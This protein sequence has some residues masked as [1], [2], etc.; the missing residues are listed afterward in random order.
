MAK[1]VP[2]L[3]GLTKMIDGFYPELK[4]HPPI[5]KAILRGYFQGALVR[6]HM[7]H[8]EFDEFLTLIKKRCWYCGRKPSARKWSNI[9]NKGFAWNGIDRIDNDLPYTLDN[10]VSCCQTCNQWKKNKKRVDFLTHVKKIAEHQT[11]T[12]S[13][14]PKLGEDMDN[15]LWTTDTGSGGSS[16]ARHL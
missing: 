5:V 4:D 7:F 14:W 15:G 10:V 13:W 8:L 2:S 11:R 6:G 9:G 1:E 16:L 3:K 12:N